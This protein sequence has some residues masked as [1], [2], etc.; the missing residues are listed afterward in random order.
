M[1]S[2]TVGILIIIAIVIIGIA[3]G[4]EI[5]R[6]GSPITISSNAT[7]TE[8]LRTENS[9]DYTSNVSPNSTL[10]Y[11]S[12]EYSYVDSRGQT[13]FAPYEG[14]V[15][16]A[17]INN[18]GSFDEYVSLNFALDKGETLLITGWKLRSVRTGQETVIGGAANIPTVGVKDQSPI[19]LTSRS[20]VVVSIGNSPINTSFRINKCS[21]FLEEKNNFHPQLWTS[22][23]RV[24]DDAPD[25]SKNINDK[26]LDY[27][28]G[29]P[30]CRVPKERDFKDL[31]LSNSCETFLKTKVNYPTC[32]ANHAGDADFLEDEWRVYTNYRGL[33]GLKER[34]SIEL[35]DNAGRVVDTYAI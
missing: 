34:D 7:T 15:S 33:F 27:L 24:I 12:P 29:L 30:I 14:K 1:S 22:C 16:I 17:S 6:S 26:C 8:E 18:P 9:Y 13:V 2:N 5:F 4:G 28:E 35:L 21:G 23:P 32:V 31:G 3:S 25:L 11:N 20:R 10:V 19:V